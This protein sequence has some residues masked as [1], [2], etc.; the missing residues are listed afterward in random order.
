M[1]FEKLIWECNGR[2]QGANPTIR[3]A[4]VLRTSYSRVSPLWASVD[5]I[6]I[7]LIC[8]IGPYENV[9]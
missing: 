2:P 8:I 7:L 6:T 3:R 4:C 1:L 9:S 5:L